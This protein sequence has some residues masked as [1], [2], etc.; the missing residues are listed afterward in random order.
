MSDCMLIQ[1][2]T[3]FPE[4]FGPAFDVGMIGQARKKS[5]AEIGVID[6][7]RFTRDKHRT[8]DD[9]PYGG[10][11]GMVMK[12]EPIFEAVERCRQESE[13][14]AHVVLLTPQGKR[15]DQL[16]AKELSLRKQLVLICGRYEGVDQRVADYLTDEEISVGDFVLS[17]G[18]FA[19]LL[20]V[21]AVSR[22]IPG[23]VG[24]GDSVLAESF[25]DGLL[26]YPQYTRPAEFRSWKVPKV[27]LDGNH[28]KIRSWRERQS[29]ERTRERRPD[30]MERMKDTI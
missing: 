13:F 16:K 15:F 14:P 19:A 10:G 29:L 5:L 9:R 3:I 18:E 30:L 22:L 23:V 8:V 11:E 12:L 6:L 1:V 2:V 28:Q 27:L 24:K 7:R 26:D 20:I 21:D 25:M 4:L 17:G